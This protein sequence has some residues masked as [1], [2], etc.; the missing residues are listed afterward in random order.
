M[1]DEVWR[2]AAQ[3][4]SPSGGRMIDEGWVQVQLAK[5]YAKLEALKV[6]NWR[7]AWSI[8]HGVPDMAEASAL[9]VFGTEFLGEA[10][11]LLLEIVGAAG[12]IKEG[13]PG[14][15][16]DGLLESSYR[17][18]GTYTFGGG[19]NEVMRDIIAAAGLG[20]PRA[21]ARS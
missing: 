4:P 19:V 16:F 10:Y 1:L 18:A 3:T 21:R 17:T 8:N 7:S 20:L 2:W 11:A 12:G 5:V 15:V 9:K 14:A 13:S 6:L